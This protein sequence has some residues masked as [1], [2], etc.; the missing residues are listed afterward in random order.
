MTT[1]AY[2]T[3]L[4]AQGVRARLACLT[5][6]RDLGRRQI[7]LIDEGNVSGLLDVLGVKQRPLT[8]LQRIEQVLKPFRDQDPA[9]R[10]WRTPADR[11]ACAEQ[12]RQCEELL[13]EIVTQEKRCESVLRLRRDETAA[14]LRGFHTAGQAH[15]AYAAAPAA[16]IRQIDLFSGK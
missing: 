9:R 13:R 2:D 3:D 15:G 11:D 5:Q 12:A 14:R 6:L 4:L 16:Q 1:T 10:R 7:A 8:D